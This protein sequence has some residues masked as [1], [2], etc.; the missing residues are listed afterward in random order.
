MRFAISYNAAFLGADPDR[1]VAFARHAESCGFEA[2]YVPE[3]VV[4]YPGAMLGEAPLPTS[5]PF[6][7]PL[8]TL[9]FVAAAT[10]SILLGTGVLL[11]PYH[12]PVVL[13]KRLATIDVLSKGRLRLLTVGVGSLEGEARAVGVDFRTRGRRTDEAIDVLRLLWSGG[14]DGVS[15]HGE[16]YDLENLCSYPKPYDGAGMPIHVGGSSPPAAR[17]A[18]RR[19]DGYFAGG[20]LTPSARAHLLD[21]AR[22]AATDAGR[23]PTALEYTR[24]G[25][26]DATGEQVEV[27]AQQGVTRIVVNPTSTDP[28]EQRDQL[29]AFADR[30]ALRR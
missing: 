8:D 24:W 23:D 19:G 7:D 13:A 29:D 14:E 10:E 17:R 4:L 6:L 25:S 22:E 28:A 1:I 26:I 11:L 21:L 20:L 16:F 2:L 9:S 30:F 12:H 27:L 5:L 3:H 18:G 15:Y